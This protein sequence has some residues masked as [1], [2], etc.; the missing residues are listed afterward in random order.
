MGKNVYQFYDVFV[1]K[2]EKKKKEK[3]GLI[4]WNNNLSTKVQKQLKYQ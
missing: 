1:L 2:G 4:T 3:T